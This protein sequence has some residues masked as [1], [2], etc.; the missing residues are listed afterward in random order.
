MK[1]IITESTLKKIIREIAI[2]SHAIDR[3]T[4]RFIE[5]SPYD[6]VAF[7]KRNFEQ[8]VIG[9]YYINQDTINRVNDTMNK[10]ADPIYVVPRNIS[11]IIELYRF[12]LNNNNIDFIG[13]PHDIARYKNMVRDTNNWNIYLRTNPIGNE[14]VSYGR[15]LICITNGNL[16]KTIFFIADDNRMLKR[17]IEFFKQNPAHKYT[18]DFI[19]ISNPETQLDDYIDIDYLRSQQQKAHKEPE[20]E[21]LDRPVMTDRERRLQAYKER[22]KKNR[23][24]GKK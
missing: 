17:S 20:P 3:L 24:F 21:I 8:I 10:L 5:Q 16:V 15:I 7:S 22:M 1:I 23:K 4:Q 6:V 13:T 18:E 9:K 12:D 14:H 2:D 11:L 19:F